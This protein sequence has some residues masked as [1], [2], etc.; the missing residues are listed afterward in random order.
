MSIS[1]GK[2]ESRSR[3]RQFVDPAQVPFLAD[4]RKRGQELSQAQGQTI[5]GVADQ[6]S[7]RLGGIGDQLL[8]GLV[9]QSGLFGPGVAQAQEL[10][11]G[12]ASGEGQFGIQ[13][14]LQPGEALAG[15]LSFLDEN[16]QRNLA[17]TLGT[18]GG[19][20]T[21]QGQTGGD[22]QAFFS[23]EA[24]GE[25]QRAFAG[26]AS[27]L[28]SA[29][30]AARRQLSGV[31]AGQQLGAATALGGLGIEQQRIGA[32]TATA[33]LNQLGGLFNLG[34]AP[35]N[36]QFQPLKDFAQILGQSVVLGRGTSSASSAEF[37]VGFA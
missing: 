8:G 2:S 18:L 24:A 35:F 7:G 20:A 13:Q 31:A 25:A 9:E 1:G 27:N 6:L 29:D 23:S 34:L 4:L 16:I 28:L 15:Q 30:I 10:L 12:I 14:L 22:R 21:L 11:G 33:G 19:Q 26:G 32:Q 17:S 36:A 3:S 37:G 5:G